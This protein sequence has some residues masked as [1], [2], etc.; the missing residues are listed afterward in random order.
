MAYDP[1][2]ATA[3]DPLRR[4]YEAQLRKQSAPLVRDVGERLEDIEGFIKYAADV[5]PDFK[6]LLVGWQVRKRIGIEG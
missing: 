3:Y 1:R 5:D 2:S 6:K 4:Q